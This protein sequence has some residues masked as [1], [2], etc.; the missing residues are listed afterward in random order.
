MSRILAVDNLI[1]VIVGMVYAI[2]CNQTQSKYSFRN[3]VLY[4]TMNKHINL[5]TFLHLR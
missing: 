5:G 3:E 1:R 2:K 4:V